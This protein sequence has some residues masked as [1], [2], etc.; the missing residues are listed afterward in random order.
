MKYFLTLMFTIAMGI[1][2]GAYGLNFIEQPI[3]YSLVN[4]PA[5]AAFTGLVWLIERRMS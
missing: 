5:I 4:F 2:S 3:L 1:G